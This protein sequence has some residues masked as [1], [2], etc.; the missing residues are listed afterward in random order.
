[1]SKINIFVVAH[2]DKKYVRIPRYYQYIKVGKNKEKFGKDYISDDT[3]DNISKKNENYCELTA[4]YWIWK[5]YKIDEYIGICHYRRFFINL[6]FFNLL[7]ENKILKIMRKFDVILPKTVYMKEGIW[8]HFSHGISGK[9]KDLESLQ[10]LIKNKYNDYYDSFNEVMFGKKLSYYNM[11]IMKK[12]DFSNYCE[13]LF[14]LL[15]EF[16]NY[17]DLTYYT[18]QQRRIYGFMSEFLLNVWVKKNN[19][20]VKYEPVLLYDDKH[21]RN[22]GRKIKILLSIFKKD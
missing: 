22:I 7:N 18:I 9:E 21:L 2:K 19:L 13:W 6:P 20:K 14:E 3:K 1:M 5:N 8:N 12:K 17:I 15:N 10:K 4:I 11:F 16:E